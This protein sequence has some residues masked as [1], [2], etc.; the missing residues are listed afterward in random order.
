MANYFILTLDTTG[1]ASPGIL[2]EGGNTYATQQLID[3][4]ISTG[5]GDTTGYQMKIWGDVDTSN[6][7]DVQD[8]ENNSNWIS[9]A[10]TKQI[11]LSAGDGNKTINVKLRD[12]V[13]NES[14]QASDSITLDTTRPVVSISGPDVNKISKVDGKD[15]CSFSFQVDTTF[16][17]YK[18]KYVA[19][20]G[21]A[22]DTG[23]QIGTANGS[24]NMSGNAGGYPASTPIDCIINGADL[25]IANA[26][27]TAKT[28]KIFVK[29]QAGNWS[30]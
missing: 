25:E 4:A 19:S 6:D 8:T 15:E 30:V 20:S 12:D 1:P 2:L 11:K 21:A 3:A 18:V 28:I 5:D 10:S 23:T 27:D 7:P 26:G 24:S 16:D 17:E 14:S 29:D 22:H 13:W 9:F